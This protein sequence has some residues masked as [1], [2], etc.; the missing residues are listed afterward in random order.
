VVEILE[1]RVRRFT[2]PEDRKH[3]H[4]G[5][6]KSE[7]LIRRKAP[8]WG[9]ADVISSQRE[10]KN[11]NFGSPMG[12]NP[13]AFVFPKLRSDEDRPSL[14]TRGNNLDFQG[15][16]QKGN[17]IRRS[18]FGGSGILRTRGP[19][20]FGFRKPKIPKGDRTAVI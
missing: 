17:H 9:L 5:T 15:K 11:R 20:H 13:K 16:S 3:L 6:A 2:N 8:L 10:V 7:I 4:F 12:K 19:I 18:K 1:V 14:R